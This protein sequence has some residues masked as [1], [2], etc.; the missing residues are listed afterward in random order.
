MSQIYVTMYC[1]S[2]TARD[3]SAKHDDF[4]S[5]SDTVLKQADSTNQNIGYLYC[6]NAVLNFVFVTEIAIQGTENDFILFCC[7]ENIAYEGNN[8]TA[9]WNFNNNYS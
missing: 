5:S 8:P 6:P 1:L 7:Y 2:D 3:Y 9:L 4:L